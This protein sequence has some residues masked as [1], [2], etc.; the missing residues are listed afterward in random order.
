LTTPLYCGFCVLSSFLLNHDWFFLAY[1]GKLRTTS[2]PPILPS[3]ADQK[4]AAPRGPFER[5][6]VLVLGCAFAVVILVAILYA[7][8]LPRSGFIEMRPPTARRPGTVSPL[9]VMDR[10]GFHIEKVSNFLNSLGRRPAPPN[11][12]IVGYAPTTT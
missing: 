8:S 1:E 11:N 2:L 4:S 3:E 9:P 5:V 12:S 6:A 10:A 7:A